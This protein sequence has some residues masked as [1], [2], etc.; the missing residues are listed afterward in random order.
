MMASILVPMLVSWTKQVGSAT[1][2]LA[3]ATA[4]AASI[5]RPVAT[6]DEMAEEASGGTLKSPSTREPSNSGH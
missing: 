3:A 2:P 4:A 1:T 6:A 5:Q